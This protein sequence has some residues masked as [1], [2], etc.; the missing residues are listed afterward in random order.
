MKAV[1]RSFSSWCGKILGQDPNLKKPSTALSKASRPDFL[2]ATLWVTGLD[3]PKVRWMAGKL[4]TIQRGRLEH[5]Q[6]K[7]VSVGKASIKHV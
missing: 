5:P 6:T 2:Q 1:R 7:W 3:E 4:A